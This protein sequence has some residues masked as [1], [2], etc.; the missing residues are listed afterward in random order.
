[1]REDLRPAFMFDDLS[2]AD[3]IHVRTAHATDVP[4]LAL[5]DTRDFKLNVSQPYPD[6]HIESVKLQTL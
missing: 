4:A 3:L 1:M 2:G 5:K 6:T